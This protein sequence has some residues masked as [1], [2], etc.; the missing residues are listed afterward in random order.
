ML[1]AQLYF[2]SEKWRRHADPGCATPNP[3]NVSCLVR[4]EQIMLVDYCESLVRLQELDKK[5]ARMEAVQCHQTVLDRVGSWV[6]GNPLVN[7]PWSGYFGEMMHFE[8][9]CGSYLGSD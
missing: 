7:P 8:S 3:V 1:S 9:Y 5:T 2:P 6:N 4:V